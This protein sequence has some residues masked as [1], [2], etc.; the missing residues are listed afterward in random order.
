MV[1]PLPPAA[2]GFY[3]D[4][5][6]QMDESHL[7]RPTTSFS[8]RDLNEGRV[9]YITEAGEGA[10]HNLHHE[11]SPLGQPYNILPTHTNEI[12]R[13]MTENNGYSDVIV[14]SVSDSSN[15]PNVLED[16]KFLVQVQE[17][18]MLIEETVT[19][20]ALDENQLELQVSTKENYRYL[21]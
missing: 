4:G 13:H 14:F 3:N 20:V 12:S 17:P 5:W 8:Q 15:P 18:I 11:S 10:R 16:Q 6:V 1:I 2:D 21:I 9:W 7:L 19:Q